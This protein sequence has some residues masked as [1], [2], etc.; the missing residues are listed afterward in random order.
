MLSAVG[1]LNDWPGT[2]KMMADRGLPAVDVLLSTAVGLELVGGLLVMLGLYAR[3]GA[4]AL[5]MFLATLALVSM[6]VN[7]EARH[8]AA[9]PA[10]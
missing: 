10:E 3:W 1:K 7:I 6:I 5:L 8:A 4:L 9:Q 2:A